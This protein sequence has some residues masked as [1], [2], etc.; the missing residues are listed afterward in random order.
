MLMRRWFGDGVYNGCTICES[1]YGLKSTIM[2]C[3]LVTGACVVDD[4]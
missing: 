4:G 3:G 1:Y 2:G